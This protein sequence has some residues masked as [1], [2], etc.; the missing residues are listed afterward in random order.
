MYSFSLVGVLFCIN[1]CTWQP[2]EVGAYI[3]APELQDRWITNA[4]VFKEARFCGF[5]AAKGFVFA[6]ARKRYVLTELSKFFV[7]EPWGSCVHGV[8]VLFQDLQ[9]WC[10]PCRMKLEV[11]VLCLV[12]MLVLPQAAGQ[13]IWTRLY[14]WQNI[15]L[16]RPPSERYEFV[17]D[18]CASG[19]CFSQTP[20]HPPAPAPC[21]AKQQ[22]SL[23]TQWYSCWNRT[24]HPTQPDPTNVLGMRLSW[25]WPLH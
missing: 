1:V 12:L 2:W 25:N 15:T 21:S 8:H 4:F 19:W 18:L 13:L 3:W 22:N 7:H 24:V 11:T 17:N 20:P 5:P 10:E 16:I 14:A 6:S 9:L 23:Q